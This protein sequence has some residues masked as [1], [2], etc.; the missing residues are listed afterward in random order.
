MTHFPSLLRLLSGLG[1]LHA[2]WLMAQVSCWWLPKEVPQSLVMNTYP[3]GSSQHVNSLC[4]HEQVK[5]TREI[6]QT[7]H[8]SCHV[9]FWAEVTKFSPDSKSQKLHQVLNTG[10]QGLLMA[11]KKLLTT[12]L[13]SYDHL[14]QWRINILRILLFPLFLMDLVILL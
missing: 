11:F 2:A 12:V 7:S 14:N 13:N 8:H 4:Y 1:S 10:K 3:P 6:L 5:R 9:L